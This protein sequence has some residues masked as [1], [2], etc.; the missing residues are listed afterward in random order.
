[1][2]PRLPGLRV[3]RPS[4]PTACN[5]I[6]GGLTGREVALLTR[7]RSLKEALRGAPP[8]ERPALIR[9]LEALKAHRQEARRE[10]MALLGHLPEEPQ[11][12]EPTSPAPPAP[13]PLVP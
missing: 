2:D 3:L 5:T 8:A 6:R 4:A 11:A 9:S 7:M 13:D 10:R 12:A 1:M